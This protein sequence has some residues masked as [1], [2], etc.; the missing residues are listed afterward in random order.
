MVYWRRRGGAGLKPNVCPVCEEDTCTQHESSR[1]VVW[2]TLIILMA[3]AWYF[4]LGPEPLM[5]VDEERKENL[6]A[7]INDQL[8]YEAVR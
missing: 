6:E 8:E 2:V 3:L 1:W 7:E 5:P 4:H